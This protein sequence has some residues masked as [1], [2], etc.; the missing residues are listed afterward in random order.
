MEDCDS[1]P[2]GSIPSDLEAKT[3]S[4][5]K[6]M[7]KLMDKFM[8]ECYRNRERDLYQFADHQERLDYTSNLAK[9]S[10]ALV[11][12]TPLTSEFFKSFLRLFF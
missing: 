6:K 3:G 5:V 2:T 8:K 10:Y 9:A 12:G 4:E 11:T 1:I 7:Q